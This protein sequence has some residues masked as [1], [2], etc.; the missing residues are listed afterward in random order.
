MNLIL[1]DANGNL[2]EATHWGSDCTECGNATCGAQTCSECG[3]AER[4][5]PLWVLTDPPGDGGS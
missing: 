3:S 5:V 1:T 4:S 2:Y